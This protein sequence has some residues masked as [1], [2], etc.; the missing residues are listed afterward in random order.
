MAAPKRATQ[1]APARTGALGHG[2]L[3]AA[4]LDAGRAL[5]DLLAHEVDRVAHGANAGVCRRGERHARDSE[6]RAHQQDPHL[7]RPTS[8]S[9]GTG[10]GMQGPATLSQTQL[11]VS[12]TFPVH[13]CAGAAVAAASGSASAAAATQTLTFSIEIPLR[14][15]RRDGPQHSKHGD[16][17]ARF[18]GVST[19][20]SPIRVNCAELFGSRRSAPVRA[21][22]VLPPGPSGTRGPSGRPR[23]APP[24]PAPSTTNTHRESE[25]GS[26]AIPV[27]ANRRP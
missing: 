17:N 27:E 24:A 14:S 19:R 8:C 15:F 10:Y 11:I 2:L 12:H 1:R 5:R 7:Q 22:A 23:P 21:G 26:L 9:V 6:Q 4:L 18:A 25:R 3:R 13:A 16:V 20:K